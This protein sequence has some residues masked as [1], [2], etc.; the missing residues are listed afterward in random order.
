[1][2]TRI[3]NFFKPMWRTI[4]IA[5]AGQVLFLISAFTMMPLRMFE[6]PVVN[7]NLFYVPILALILGYLFYRCCTETQ[8]ARGYLFGFFAA[9]FAWPLI[10]E[11]ATIPV[12][13]GV[14][15]QFSDFNLKGLGAYFYVLACWALLHI[16]W[17]T[18]GA[19]LRSRGA[20]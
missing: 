17:R 15:T 19:I 10:G 2:L 18:A 16:M 1:M 8:E 7:Y 3:K 14:I 20:Y 4:W 11:V 13:K 9:V 12:D 6:N 5:L